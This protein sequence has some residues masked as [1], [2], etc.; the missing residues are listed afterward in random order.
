MAGRAH[1]LQVP[2]AR[3]NLR[4]SI[5]SLR[6]RALLSAILFS[7]LACHGQSSGVAEYDVKAT[8]LY[9]F[10]KF[11]D[12]PAN[13]TA[14]N[15]SP[16]VL[17]IVGADPFGSAL[18]RI[19]RGQRI[20]QHEILIRR[21]RNSDDLTICQIAFVSRA[22]NKNLPVILDRL[23]ASST[24]VVGDAQDFARRGGG[25]QLYLEDNAVHFSINVDSVQRSHLA[26]SSNVL[27]LA[28]IVHDIP[29][30]KTN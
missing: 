6:L 26:I 1:T 23:K 13:T 22:E 8:F 25:I 12:W 20:D 5:P 17:C 24:L 18:D 10:A 11:V 27:A 2:A 19:V 29:S 28:T 15:R 30:T 4:F 9:D 21:V 3:M 7:S 16:F 14:S